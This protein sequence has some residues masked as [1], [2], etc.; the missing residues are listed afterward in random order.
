MDQILFETHLKT[1]T[2]EQNIYRCL[3]IRIKSKKEL[4]GEKAAVNAGNT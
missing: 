4:E 3:L 2:E 1:M